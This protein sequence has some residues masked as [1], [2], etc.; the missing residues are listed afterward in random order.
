[1]TNSRNDGRPDRES[2]TDYAPGTTP[3][4]GDASDV[5]AAKAD[6]GTS[7]TDA[8]VY[9]SDPGPTTGDTTGKDPQGADDTRNRS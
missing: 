5:S 7:D 2:P 6:T 4:R 1:M 3:D 9:D 8:A